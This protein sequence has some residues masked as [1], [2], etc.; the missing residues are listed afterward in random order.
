MHLTFSTLSCPAWSLD[1]ILRVATE[2]GYAGVETRGL[3]E[4][5]DLRQSPAFQ[6]SQRAQTRGSFRRL[7]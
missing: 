6:A 3:Q 7:E 2:N 1:Q 5:V 4:H